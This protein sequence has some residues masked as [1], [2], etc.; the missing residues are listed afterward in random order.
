MV[1][2]LRILT[3]FLTLSC[4]DLRW[5]KLPYFINK[6]NFLSISEP[7]LKN[8]SCQEQRN[9]LSNNPVPVARHFQYKVEAF[10]KEI[11]LDGPLG[12]TKYYAIRIEFQEMGSPHV[13]SFIWIL[14]APNTI[15]ETAYIE[16]T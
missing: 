8:L 13:H 1:K 14:N 7:R 15:N 10:F 2:Q 11:I 9:L 12:K 5:E 6:L 3:Y 16:F 4:A